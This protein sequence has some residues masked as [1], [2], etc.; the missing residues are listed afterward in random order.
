[1]LVPTDFSSCANV[2]VRRALDVVRPE[3]TLTLLYVVELPVAIADGAPILAPDTEVQERARDRLAKLQR[4]LRGTTSVKINT[5]LRIGPPAVEIIERIGTDATI[6]LVVVG[7]HGRTGIKRALLGSV[8]EKIVRHAAR[9][10]LV[11]R[12]K[13]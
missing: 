13:D 9:P 5:E 1:V 6:D 12:N 8:A 10:V 7:S 11:A 3:G 4:E 2:A